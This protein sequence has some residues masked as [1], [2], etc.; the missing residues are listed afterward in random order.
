MAKPTFTDLWELL[1][2]DFETGKLWW[3]PR[4]QKHFQCERHMNAW[5]TRYSSTQASTKS[6][7]SDPYKL[8]SIKGI[9]Y[10][11]HHII[12]A[13]CY[14]EWPDG[15]I[16]H[17]DGDKFNNKLSN[18][19]VVNSM[20]NNRNKSMHK[21]N[22]S[23]ITGVYFKLRNSKWAAY[24]TSNYEKIHLGIYSDFE[25][26]VRVRKQAEI[27]YGYHPNHGRPGR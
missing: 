21:N 10:K 20:E 4:D 2:Y 14:F 17:I 23:G 25:E 16:D 1:N 9:N 18:L 6:K 22:K 24:I 5:N 27:D 13:M 11:E 8:I 7:K 15:V 19:R 26:A 3:K 12:W